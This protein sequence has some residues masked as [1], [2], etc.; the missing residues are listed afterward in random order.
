MQGDGAAPRGWNVRVNDL[1]RAIRNPIR[2]IV[3]SIRPAGGP[4]CGKVRAAARLRAPRGAEGPPWG[5]SCSHFGHLPLPPRPS[6]CT[7]L[8]G[9]PQCVH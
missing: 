4:A 5:I 2:E 9:P 6:R 7:Q 3:E 8:L 1:V